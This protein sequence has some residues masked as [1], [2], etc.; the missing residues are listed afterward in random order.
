MNK[1][2]EKEA[3]NL[4]KEL[5]KFLDVLDTIVFDH[6]PLDDVDKI[7]SFDIKQFHKKMK[8]MIEKNEKAIKRMKAL[9]STLESKLEVDESEKT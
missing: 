1:L 2:N 8:K 7:Q 4:H 9:I 5:E 6:E 3:N